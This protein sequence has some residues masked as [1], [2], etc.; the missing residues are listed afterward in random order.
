MRLALLLAALVP[1]A[2]LAQPLRPVRVA[3]PPAAEE[4]AEMGRSVA[5]DGD[6]AAVVAYWTATVEVFERRKG[7]WAH[8]ARLRTDPLTRPERS[9]DLALSGDLLVVGA[10]FLHGPVPGDPDRTPPDGGVFVFEREPGG[11]AQTALLRGR[12][13][14][15]E[16]LGLDVAASAGRILASVQPTDATPGAVA[17]VIEPT[18]AGWAVTDTLR[19]PPGVDA[20][21]GPDVELDGDRAL[22]RPERPGHLYVFEH[23]PGGWPLTADLAFDEGSFVQ[24]AALDGDRIAV[25]IV[26]VPDRRVYAGSVVV[27]ERTSAGWAP[28]DTLAAS[29]PSDSGAFGDPLVLDGDR[30]VTSFLPP[31]PRARSVHVFERGAGG[32]TE[33]VLPEPEGRAFDGFGSDLALDGDRLVVGAPHAD[34]GAV[35]A[36]GRAVVYDLGVGARLEPGSLALGPAREGDRFGSGVAL[37]VDRLAA[38]LPGAGAV[39][40]YERTALPGGAEAWTEEARLFPADG[41]VDTLTLALDGGRLAVGIPS[42]GR[43]VVYDRGPDGWAS[44]GAVERAP[45]TAF[46]A[47]VALDA[48]RV[49]AGIPGDGPAGG[50]VVLAYEAGRWV[51]TAT[52]RPVDPKGQRF[53]GAVALDGDR[54]LVGARRTLGDVPGAAAAFRFDGGRWV[55]DGLYTGSLGAFG[56]AVALDGDSGLVGAPRTEQ[57]GPGPLVLLDLAGGRVGSEV[58]VPPHHPFF[59]SALALDGARAVV[60]APSPAGEGAAFTVD[61]GGGAPVTLPRPE[62]LAAGAG[63]GRTVAAGAGR[64]AVGAP[65]EHDGSPGAGAVYVY[66]VGQPVTAEP[67]P[68]APAGLRL[69]IP[70]P[71]PARGRTRVTL[72]LARRGTATLVVLD[73]LGRR[74]LSEVRDLAAG[75]NDADLDVR[76]LAAGTY[77]VRATVGSA[78]ATQR[79]VVGR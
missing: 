17:F 68:A 18:A 9:A 37:G 77:L 36:A 59:G 4:N 32:W 31:G 39:A 50:A 34:V 51:E 48:G 65:A 53:G 67:D 42:A 64:V 47:A 55:A 24:D 16:F 19:T 26:E 40:R 46:G 7:R 3:P 11:W 27:L 33:T 6:R 74:V 76:G 28:A 71:N 23:G 10:P 78:S 60:G 5:L 44:A 22:V 20:G 21:F 38:A 8:A 1:A 73:V 61:L 54:A 57:G 14:S 70:A 2:A 56:A 69:S 75:L 49:L 63:F 52:L 30:V 35:P 29:I 79:L 62:G 43:V 15:G 12:A 45:A 25:S 72:D 58:R 13:G 66:A 41:A